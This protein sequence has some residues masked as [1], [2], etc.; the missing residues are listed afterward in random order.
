MRAR[1]FTLVEVLVA[2]T[3]SVVLALI[4][5]PSYQGQLLRAGRSEGIEALQ[6]IQLAQERHRETFGVYATEL[7][8]LGFAATTGGGRY[9]LALQ[10]LG[11]Q[12][13][14]LSA[15]PQPGSPQAADSACPMLGLEV[16]EGFATQ[17]PDGRCW[18]R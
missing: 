3:V 10:P 12:T 7:R 15:Q 14:R 5:W 13:Y 1:G 2:S 16:R 11:A 9:A 17:G 18:N 8:T 4:A 6:R